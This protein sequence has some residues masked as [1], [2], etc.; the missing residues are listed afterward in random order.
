MDDGQQHRLDVLHRL[1]QE[2]LSAHQA[3]VKEAPARER[4]AKSDL[5]VE[6]LTP[7]AKKS[8]SASTRLARGSRRG[9][10]WTLLGG[11]ALLAV[12]LMGLFA[13]SRFLTPPTP[14]PTPGPENAL[15]VTSNFNSGTVTVNGKKV[16]GSFPLLVRLNPGENTIIF[17]APPFRDQTCRVTLLPQ[18]DAQSGS[19]VRAVEEKCGV[20]VQEPPLT[21]NG[22]AVKNGALVFGMTGDDLPADVRNAAENALWAKLANSRTFQVPAGDYYATGVDAS[23][24][25][26]SARAAVALLAT[27]ALARPTTAQAGFCLN[28]SC[29]GHPI[30]PDQGGVAPPSGTWLIQDAVVVGWRFTTQGGALVAASPSQFAGDTV[31]AGLTYSASAGWSVGDSSLGPSITDLQ[32]QLLSGSCKSGFSALQMLIGQSSLGGQ[33]LT[34]GQSAPPG[35]TTDGCA[36]SVGGQN[37][38][39]LSPT[40]SSKEYGHYIWRWGVLLAADTQAHTLFPS[41]PIAPQNEI[42][43]VG[44]FA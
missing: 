14:T 23:G 18:P 21:L 5:V 22:V 16:E 15:I 37:T 34:Y 31:E 30:L 39:P 3:D 17:S 11:V 13:R 19:R 8:T 36:I 44:G 29:A 4:D 12:V 6:P 42:A 40:S 20:S 33:N 24:H 27:L 38:N 9:L 35:S 25:I 1:A 41:L 28:L 32:A 7:G 26:R 10:I 2:Q 43:A